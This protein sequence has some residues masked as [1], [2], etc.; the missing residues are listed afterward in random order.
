M[1]SQCALP[2]FNWKLLLWKISPNII[3]FPTN[4]FSLLGKLYLIAKPATVLK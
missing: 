2:F 4:D 1:S 3:Y